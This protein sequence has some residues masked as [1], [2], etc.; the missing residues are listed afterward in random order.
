MADARRPTALE[1]P[2]GDRLTIL[3]G[4]VVL[5][6][7]LGWFAPLL[8]RWVADQAWVPFSGP[9]EQ[10]ARLTD[11]WGGWGQWVAVAGLVL[12]GVIAGFVLISLSTT[13]TVSD[14]ALLVHKGS[15]RTRYARAQVRHVELDGRRLSLRD[16]D[17]ID[18]VSVTVDVDR[19]ALREA[20]TRH[21]WPVS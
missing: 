20:L 11:L 6:G 12:L 8:S 4:C 16:A 13:V 10:V 17:D 21:D 7:L 15:D 1:V 5:G 18:L 19:D 3:G 14:A 9:I 2:G